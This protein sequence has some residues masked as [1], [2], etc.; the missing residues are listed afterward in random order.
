V[1]ILKKNSILF[2]LGVGLALISLSSILSNNKT[3][4]EVK[5]RE[6]SLQLNFKNAQL[7]I[8]KNG[9]S[10]ICDE[11]QEYMLEGKVFKQIS[12]IKE[13]LRADYWKKQKEEERIL[14]IARREEEAESRRLIDE[15]WE[16]INND[17]I[18]RIC[19]GKN[20]ACEDSPINF[21]SNWK[22]LVWCKERAC[23]DF[24]IAMEVIKNNQSV[25]YVTKESCGNEGE[26]VM[27]VLQPKINGDYLRFS[28]FQ[29]PPAGLVLNC[30]SN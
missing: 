12:E 18:Y 3:V 21:N 30:V 28:Q 7:C 9:K 2:F 10:E 8:E 14:E 22:I 24:F 6:E 20:A 16:W 1:S 19:G 25:G 29:S 13:K 15:G 4:N 5:R 23:G 17:F 26:K 27:L 11:V